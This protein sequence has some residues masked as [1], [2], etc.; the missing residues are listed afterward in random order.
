MDNANM[1]FMPYQERDAEKVVSWITSEK[2]FYQWSSGVLGEY[3]L[4]PERL[5]AFYRE[6]KTNHK[7][8]VYCLCD[9]NMEPVA[10]MILRYPEEDPRHIRF[11]FI[12]AD[13]A[14]RGRG[15]GRKMLEM[16]LAYSRDYL[17]AETVSLGVYTNNEGPIRLYESLG[18]A[19]TG[20]EEEASYMGE[21]W[22]CAEME[23]TL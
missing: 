10:Q 8:M 4:T 17:Q 3:P 22:S 16:A 13:P 11:G 5:N 1:K 2:S 21:T 20:E 9:E 12:L 6:W 19:F 14:L 15:C 18:F 7:Y 23:L